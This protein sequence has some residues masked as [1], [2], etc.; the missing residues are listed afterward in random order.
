MV[1]RGAAAIGPTR[2]A[3]AKR[4]KMLGNAPLRDPIRQAHAS[5]GRARCARAAA[6]RDELAAV[7]T[8]RMAFGAPSLGTGLQNI[9]LARIGQEG[10]ERFSNLSAVGA[11]GRCQRLS[12]MPITLRV[13]LAVKVAA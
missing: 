6:E 1:R 5:N 12:S 9:A 7:A 13:H 11:H 4:A 10:A 3:L 8:G 2:K